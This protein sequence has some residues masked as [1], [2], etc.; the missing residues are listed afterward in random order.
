VSRP[1][2][3]PLAGLRVVEMVG[4]GPAP[5]A[6]TILADFGCDV[7][8][9]ERFAPPAPDRAAVSPMMRGK[10]SVV[11]DVKTDEGRVAVRRLADAA[12]VFVDPYRPGACERLGLG[13]EVLCASNR[14]LIYAR[15]TGFG[16]DGPLA[17][18]AG[19]DINY[20]ALGGALEMIGPAGQAPVFPVNLLGD[21]AGGGMMLV[22]GIVCAA[23]E[24]E[25]S[26]LGQVIDAAMIDGVA[27][28]LG[29]M[30]M[31][32]TTG[33]WGPR[34]TNHLDGGA[35]FYNVY[36]TADR[37][38]IS[39]GAIEP[40]FH[41]E[42]YRRLGLAEPDGWETDGW[43]AEKDRLAEVFR[44]RTRDEW[45]EL[46]EGTDSC[47]APVLS[48][49][50]MLTHPHTATRGIGV[51]IHGTTQAAP[52]PRLS[53]TPATANDPCHPGQHSIT[54]VLADWTS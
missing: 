39:I 54:D 10:R 4:Q 41:A 23:Y 22:F 40:Q 27:A 17:S 49:P 37:K 14:R 11:A 18:A 2:T 31:A 36:E 28:I 15:M 51:D 53:R 1:F 19:H 42:L 43:A 34:G 7:V 8:C 32:K 33:F 44:A 13:P 50:E 47:F 52:A 24:R 3:G 16:Q 25:R 29:P 26:G 45:C 21:F 46:L 9:V 30:F 6:T 35:P 48:V 12:D 20:I 38:W 5:Y